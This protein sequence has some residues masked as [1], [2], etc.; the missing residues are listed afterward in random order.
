MNISTNGYANMVE[1]I[2]MMNNMLKMITS[3][4]VGLSKDMMKLNVVS[5][6]AG[7]GEN[8]DTSV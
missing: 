6:V 5:S 3:A 1:S 2:E 7:L 8:I 4:E